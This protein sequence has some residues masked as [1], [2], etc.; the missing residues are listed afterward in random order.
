MTIRSSTTRV[1]VL[2]R[3]GLAACMA[4]RIAVIVPSTPF[5]EQGARAFGPPLARTFGPTLGPARSPDTQLALRRSGGVSLAVY[6]PR[7]ASA[8][9]RRAARRPGTKALNTTA[10]AMTM[11]EDRT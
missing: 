8:G 2:T 7:M 3:A 1:A 6:S 5:V 10:V 4:V 11:P 9:R